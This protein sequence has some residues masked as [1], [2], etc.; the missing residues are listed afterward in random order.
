MEDPPEVNDFL[1]E[2]GEGGGGGGGP[3][4]PRPPGGVL[5]FVTTAAYGVLATGLGAG[6][7]I[8]NSVD[9][10]AFHAYNFL[11]KPAADFPV[12]MDT[13]QNAVQTAAAH[14]EPLVA[15]RAAAGGGYQ[16]AAGTRELMLRQYQKMMA[17]HAVMDWR[18][19]QETLDMFFADDG[20]ETARAKKILL[21]QY[22]AAWKA[23]ADVS[24]ETL[25]QLAR[26]QDGAFTRVDPHTLTALADILMAVI[27]MANGSAGS[28]LL[29][30]EKPLSLGGDASRMLQNLRGHRPPGGEEGGAAAGTEG[31]ESKGGSS[32]PRPA[33][34]RA[35][36]THETVTVNEIKDDKLGRY[37]YDVSVERGRPGDA[38]HSSEPAAAAAK[39]EKSVR[40]VVD[41][42]K[43]AGIDLSELSDDSSDSDGDDMLG[44]PL[45]FSGALSSGKPSQGAPSERAV[46]AEEHDGEP[47]LMGYVMIGN[48]QGTSPVSSCPISVGNAADIPQ[49]IARASVR[50]P[51]GNAT[52]PT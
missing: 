50:L 15:A 51:H 30:T 47:E 31:G 49:A 2:L 45:A 38:S 19:I 24:Q 40:V 37:Q 20:G 29:H 4:A 21:S 8:A 14:N 9:E 7:T 22:T 3:R 34:P 33:L 26:V 12:Q 25:A 42:G 28:S 23:K 17:F 41:L 18:H 5:G 13:L 43:M 11:L 36:I 46:E 44:L 27:R 48:L 10:W 52:G 39:K 35:T 32:K 16:M 6:T 1:E